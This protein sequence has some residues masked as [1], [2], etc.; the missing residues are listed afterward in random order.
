MRRWLCA[1]GVGPYG[2]EA[3]G[4]AKS[5]HSYSVRRNRISESGAL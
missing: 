5:V 2:S 3:S 1:D 4:P